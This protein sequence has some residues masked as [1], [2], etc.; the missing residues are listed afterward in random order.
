MIQ[1]YLRVFRLCYKRYSKK[2]LSC[3]LLVA[4][5]MPLYIL[6]VVCFKNLSNH[7]E[8]IQNGLWIF[9][10]A[11]CSF[12][13]RLFA[14]LNLFQC[15]KVNPTRDMQIALFKHFLRLPTQ[16]YQQLPCGELT[17]L[18]FSQIIGGWFAHGIVKTIYYSI[19]ALALFSLIAYI[20]FHLGMLSSLPVLILIFT[21]SRLAR[22]F[23]KIHA[24]TAKANARFDSFIASSLRGILTVKLYNANALHFSRA[25][26]LARIKN[27]FWLK[28][29][30]LGEGVR[31]LSLGLPLLAIPLFWII[32][33][34]L[35]SQDQTVAPLLIPL[36]IILN[37][38]NRTI[39]KVGSLLGSALNYGGQL[40]VILDFFEQEQEG[41]QHFPFERGCFELQN[42]S[43]TYPESDKAALDNLSLK[44]ESEEKV[45][46]VG[47]SGSGKSTLLSMLLGM[48]SPHSGTVVVDG[49]TVSQDN[50]TSL[51]SNIASVSQ[52]A[53][54]FNSDLY[55]NLT[56]GRAIPNSE[57]RKALNF[58]GLEKFVDALPQ[59]MA[60]CLGA[61]G[62]SVS[63]GEKIRLC[64]ARAILLDRPV[65]FLDEFTANIDSI[66]EEQILSAVLRNT[67]HKTIISISHRLS[68]VRRFPCITYLDRGIIAAKGT[69]HQLLVQSSQY[70]E[71]FGKQIKQ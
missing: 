70:K 10:L 55:F 45:A 41:T 64:L 14:D 5:E 15:A 11:A 34:Y 30:F 20:S 61:N 1:V 16:K 56:L 29:D 9:C 33:G 26:E 66:C 44:I 52:S 71:L 36:Y 49:T 12:C 21:L 23:I 50:G 57:I 6:M 8:P 63:G 22:P 69:H 24:Q 19:H 3:L 43:F 13:I 67:N 51:R 60:T 54:L 17:N 7:V 32:G 39:T 25:Q 40:K 4:L 48:Y 31:S 35:V 68:S 2:M 38:L 58:V 37:L 18:L 65:L 53:Y 42:V 62:F 28:G 27:W 47:A 59:G 46:V